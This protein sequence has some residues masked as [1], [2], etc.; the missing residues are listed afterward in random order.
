[1]TE[2]KTQESLLNAL[3]NALRHQPTHEELR[4]QR[5]SFIMGCIGNSSNVTRSRVQEI[6]DKQEGRKAS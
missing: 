1:M 2:L 6:L 3:R 5:I 4:K